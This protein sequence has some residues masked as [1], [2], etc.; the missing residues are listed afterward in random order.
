MCE[1]SGEEWELKRTRRRKEIIRK[2]KESNKEKG[3]TSYWNLGSETLKQRITRENVSKCCSIA[4]KHT[5][6]NTLQL[7][8][9]NNHDHLPTPSVANDMHICRWNSGMGYSKEF[10]PQT[11]PREY[12]WQNVTLSGKLTL[13]LH[14]TRRLLR[15]LPEKLPIVQPFSKFP[16]ILRNAK[17]HHRVH[18][19]PPL[20]PILSQFDPVHTIPY[21]LSK[22]HFNIVHP[23]TSWP[24]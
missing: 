9:D 11:F 21:Y 8:P 20:V 24:S 17:V 15:T 18:N 2:K 12:P 13:K 14:F 3:T 1:A 22:I 5:T 7:S 4:F 6:E 16:A 23:P 19:S 10:S